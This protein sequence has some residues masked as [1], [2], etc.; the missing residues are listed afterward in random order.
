M[1]IGIIFWT[2][3]WPSRQNLDSIE[4]NGFKKVFFN[5]FV[6]HGTTTLFVLVE[7]LL[8]HHTYRNCIIEV[9]II[10]GYM[11]VYLAWNIAVY[12]MN[13]DWV[14]AIEGKF[15]P[16][17]FVIFVLIQVLFVFILYLFLRFL[18]Y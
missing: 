12:Y 3:L 10:Y 5:A 1:F 6:G 14:Y 17:M 9:G 15:S 11:G 18:F 7:S 8:R 16:G 2:V 13:N 4:I